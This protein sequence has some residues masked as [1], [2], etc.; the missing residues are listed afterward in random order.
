MRITE[1]LIL[2]QASLVLGSSVVFLWLYAHESIYHHVVAESLGISLFT[3]LALG[4]V[5]LDMTE[6]AWMEW[7]RWTAFVIIDY[8]IFT[9]FRARW[10]AR[11][12]QVNGEI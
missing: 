11:A 12:V 10:K 2:I 4:R 5:M 7:C 9:V 8:G 1:I 3:I 6:P